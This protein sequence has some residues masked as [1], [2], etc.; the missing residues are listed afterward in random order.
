MKFSYKAVQQ[1]FKE[2]LP[3]AK[4]LAD[5]LIFH[6]FEVEDI[7]GEGENT[8]FDI[9]VLP[10]R[11]HDAFSHMGIAKEVGAVLSMD[12][13]IPQ[14]EHVEGNDTEL[15]VSIESDKC[16]RYQAR[17][18]TGVHVTPSPAWLSLYLETLG[19]RSINALVDTTNYVLFET[20]QPVHI[21]DAD[22]IEG[23]LCIREAQEGEKVT[24]LD[25]K[26]YVLKQGTLVIADSVGILALAGIKGGVKAEVT[27][28]TKNIV[29][30]V[31]N[32][33]PVTIRKTARAMNLLTDAA[34]RFENDITP[35]LVTHGMDMATQHITEL[36]GGSV[37]KIV[38]VYKA[39]YNQK[40]V[41]V[42]VQE[43]TK[44]LG[45]TIEEKEIETIFTRLGFAFEKNDTVFIVTPPHTR[46]DIDTPAT[47]IDEIVRIYGYEKIEATLP[48]FSRNEP[49]NK[50]L[51]YSALCKKILASHGA[52]EI[53]TYAFTKKGDIEVAR[54][55]A[56]DRPALR[57]NLSS[58]LTEK[59][60][61]NDGNK[62]IL[63]VSSIALFE[64]G[65]IFKNGEESLSL[66]FGVKEGKKG[67]LFS[68]L[69]NALSEV[70]GTLPEGNNGVCEIP[71]GN[72]IET[73]PDV[74]SYGDVF[75]IPHTNQQFIPWSQFPS[76]SRDIAL[77]AKE[78][79]TVSDII[80]TIQSNAGPLLITKPRLF[81][82]FKKDEKVSYAFR[83]VFQSYE[84][85]LTDQDI[86]GPMQEIQK[87]L[88]FKGCEIR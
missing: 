54:P 61:T 9:K 57:S 21:F 23:K 32:F 37:E 47:L 30:E 69:R 42:S 84:K 22:K 80:E 65:K 2:P 39:V 73:L 41:S 33:D 10:D 3:D 79:M 51:Y 72:I 77:F 71:L 4:N 58:S 16:R 64:I 12:V 31:A 56:K 20:G 52:Y 40:T 66:S 11:S 7:E 53:S 62:D 26:E 24:L 34:K 63:G 28:D 68:T 44:T 35:E 45:I 74:E 15:A 8:T 86:D 1:Y 6:S 13:S 78:G 85:T 70:L 36:G 75:A 48:H 25:Q 88:V 81:D 60:V 67:E 87:A 14:Y 17:K 5:S 29:I 19:Q 18:I 46:L 82:S 55:L 76:S 49:I 59:L 83:M 38:D 43:V 50:E 27:N